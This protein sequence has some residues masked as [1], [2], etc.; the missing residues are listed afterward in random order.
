MKIY[1]FR[2][3]AVVCFDVEAESEVLARAAALEDQEAIR[4]GMSSDEFLAKT[5]AGYIHAKPK[6]RAVLVETYD[7]D[8]KKEK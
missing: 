7:P 8:A 2:M 5:T 4:E 6:A 1:T 3:P